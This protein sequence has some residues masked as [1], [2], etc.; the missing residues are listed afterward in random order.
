[1]WFGVV[2]LFP[3]MFS[4]LDYGITGRAI[5]DGLLNVSCWN[6]RDFTQNKHRNVDDR[7]YG[8]G[9]GML[10]MTQPLQDA[11]HA[12]KKAAPKKPTVIHLTPQG[13]QFTQTAAE[14]LLAKENLILIAGRYE[15]IDERLITLE[16]D[17]EWSIGDYILSGGELA[18]LTMID[19][20]TR[21]IP[22]ALGHEDS[23]AQD[24]L[25]SGLLKY[26]QYTRPESFQGL[27]VPEVLRGGNHQEI[28]RWRLKQSLGRT[29]LK[30]PDLLM[31]LNLDRLQLELLMEFIR[32]LKVKLSQS[33]PEGIQG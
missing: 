12:A 19:V 5:K 26:P 9:P 14:E 15:G 13:K 23:V 29:W 2:S 10:M 28:E 21:L 33:P 6:P 32:E 16:V 3:D 17:E 18:A 4:T 30:R 1:M 8:G 20:V 25:S 31:K 7:P 22:G 11:I 24:S 27:D